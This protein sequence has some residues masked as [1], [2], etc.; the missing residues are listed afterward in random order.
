MLGKKGD[1]RSDT[2]RAKVSQFK[3]NPQG[4]PSP[5]PLEECP[6]CGTQFEPDSF[7]PAPGRRQAT[8]AAHRLRQLRMRL[9][10]RALTADRGGRRAD[11]SPAAVLPHRHGGQVRE[12]ALGGRRPGSSR[13]RRARTTRPGSTARQSPARASLLPAPLPPPD[14]VIQDELHLISGPLG[15]M[16]GLYETAI[17]GLCVRDARRHGRFGRRSWRR[18]RR[19]GAPRSDPG[20][21]R[22][23]ADADLPAARP[24]PPRLVLR[25]DRAPPT[26]AR[27]ASTWASRRRAAAPRS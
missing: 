4:K 8:R 20:A 25:P 21:V 22:A 6:W 17:E 14:L 7:T 3:A 12:P 9:Q 16:A 5:I 1:G 2:A 27:H 13:R 10:R 11:L 19:C 18:P 15:T 24:R 26:R 23:R